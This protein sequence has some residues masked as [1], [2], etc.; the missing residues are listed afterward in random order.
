MD[1]TYWHRQLAGKPLYPDLLW[2]RPQNK[3]TAGKLII[4]GGNAHGFAAPAEAYSAAT[5][6]GIGTARVVLPDAIKHIAGKLLDGLSYAA[7]TPSGSFSQ[8]AYGEIMEHVPWSDGVLVCGDLGRNSQTAIVIE[9]ILTTYQGQVT[10]AKDA[11]DYGVNLAKLVCDRPQTLLV[12]T[13][14]QLQKLF[15]AMGW[16]KPITFSMD[17]L[18]LIDQLHEFTSQH[19][20]TIL[21]KHLE[22]FVVAVEGQVTT[23]P[24]PADPEELW[25]VK[26]AAQAATRWLQNAQ[27]PLAALTTSLVQD[28][29]V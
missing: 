7:S 20:V 18:Q 13:I 4:I 6:T 21:V 12:L 22:V 3:V 28:W 29:Q 9:K 11:A 17:L 25:R 27:Q 14:A 19:P 15:Q 24:A 8:Q 1:S 23:S 16:P 10:L 26:T 2:S 5:T